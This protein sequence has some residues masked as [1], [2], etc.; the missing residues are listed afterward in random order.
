MIIVAIPANA[1]VVDRVSVGEDTTSYYLWYIKGNAPDY[2]NNTYTCVPMTKNGSSYE[3]SF[4]ETL[5]QNDVFVM[6][7]T[8]SSTSI[9]DG[10][11]ALSDVTANYDPSSSFDW[12]NFTNQGDYKYIR[13]QLKESLKVKV[14]FVPSSTVTLSKDSGSTPTS[15][16]VNFGYGGT[17]T[18]EVTAKKTADSTSISNGGMVESGTSVTFT[19]NANSGSTFAGWFSDINCTKEIPDV[20]QTNSIYTT[21]ITGNTNVYAK[22]DSVPSLTSVT[23]SASKSEVAVNESF[24]L[25]AE[26]APSTVTGVTYTF[27]QNNEVIDTENTNESTITVTPTTTGTYTYKVTATSG[28]TTVPSKEINV[29][30]NALTITGVT[31]SV[32][33]ADVNVNEVF[34]LTATA[35]PAGVTDVTYT[36]YKNGEEIPTDVTSNT[37]KTTLTEEGSAEYTVTATANGKTVTSKPVTVTATNVAQVHDFTVYFKCASAP[38]YKPYVSLDGEKPVTMTQGTKLGTNYAGTLTFYWYSYTFKV[39]ST[40]THTLTFTSKKTKL[41]ATMTDNFANSEYYLA[42]DNLMSGTEVVDL[43][44]YSGSLAYIRNFFHS[45]TNMVYSGVGTDRTL[46]FTNID[47]VRRKMGE[48]ENP[49]GISTF[50]IKSATVMQM[51]TAELT[52]VSETQK[53]LLDVNLDGKVDIKDATLMQRALAS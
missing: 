27:Y 22:F 8:T 25:T 50:S 51:L 34:T 10:T 44:S 46:G 9:A 11:D 7:I 2:N 32:S 15:Y 38:A 39:D 33:N 5:A 35:S 18:G 21:A 30:V 47:G 52:T 14:T 31:L 42:V 13:C 37:Y 20:D 23:L 49:D 45:A 3:A 53:A 24:T 43:T 12:Q 16:A 40:N 36:F 4:K 26:V 29:T 17:G 28:S 41:N 6:Y 1:A 48:F 19:A